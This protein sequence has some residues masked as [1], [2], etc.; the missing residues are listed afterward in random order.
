MSSIKKIQQGQYTA[1]VSTPQKCQGDKI[2]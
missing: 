2:K 1:M